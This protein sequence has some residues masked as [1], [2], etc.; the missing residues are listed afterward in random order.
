MR[1]QFITFNLSPRHRKD[2]P[3]PQGDYI[4]IESDKPLM[5]LQYSDGDC[6]VGLNA[7]RRHS[8]L[9]LIVVPSITDGRSRYVFHTFPWDGLTIKMNMVIKG[10]NTSGLLLNDVASNHDVL[11]VTYYG[12]RG[13]FNLYR[14]QLLASSNIMVL[15]NSQ[16]GV[17]FLISAPTSAEYYR[18]YNS[19]QQFT[20]HS[21]VN[22]AQSGAPNIKHE[23]I[24]KHVPNQ[25]WNE[26]GSQRSTNKTLIGELKAVVNTQSMVYSATDD[27]THTSDSPVTLQT[28]AAV[29]TPDTFFLQHNASD[30]NKNNAHIVKRLSPTT[31]KTIAST[32]TSPVIV[33]IKQINTG[34]ASNKHSMNDIFKYRVRTRS[35]LNDFSSL[36][37]P[38]DVP[39]VVKPAKARDEINFHESESRSIWHDHN[40]KGDTSSNDAG[41]D[42]TVIAVIVSLASALILVVVCVLGFLMAEFVCR[43]DLFSSVRISPYVD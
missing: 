5:V 2:L 38:T 37:N 32:E 15:E 39:F 17:M 9:D 35:Q 42:T 11:N 34:K 20:S 3:L 7:L 33:A 18:I 13:E 29:N 23:L 25:D 24:Y 1:S 12:T 14:L 21:V 40:N 19:E 30:I 28:S 26:K 41:L 43:R 10:Q 36:L 31:S 16:P 6:V 22:E 4:S 8:C 27:H